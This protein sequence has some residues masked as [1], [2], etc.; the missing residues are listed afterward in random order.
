MSQPPSRRVRVL[1]VDDSAVVR[2]AI[3]RILQDQSDIEIVG[4]ATN[5]E[6]GVKSTVRLDPDVVILDIEMPVM[7]GITALPLILKEKPSVKVLMCSTLSARGA[8]ISIRALSLGAAECILKPGGGAVSQAADFQRELLSL[9]RS[10]AGVKI[11]P[12][13]TTAQ[14][15]P[16]RKAPNA[17]PARILAIGSST[18]GPKALIEMLTGMSGLSVPIVITQHMPKTFTSMLAKHIGE[19]TGIVCCEAEDGQEIKAGC[20]YVAPGDYHLLFRKEAEKICVKLDQGPPENFCRPSVDPML[21]SLIPVYGNRTLAVILTGMGSDGAKGCADIIDA[22]GQVI[23]QD[24]A[25]S[26]VWGMP[27]AV[28]TAG[29]CRAVLPPEQIRMTAKSIIEGRG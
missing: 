24:E 18:G 16:L 7:D 6:M 23:A 9:I 19:K 17:L 20:A 22:G 26:V 11:A 14:R 28:A 21:R 3:T 8:E 15:F 27:G 5:G 1:I 13:D 4:L 12:Q 2:S 10:L 25:S 29:L